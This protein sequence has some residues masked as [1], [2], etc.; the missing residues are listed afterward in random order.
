[1][2]SC[3][4]KF[5]ISPLLSFGVW[6]WKISCVDWQCRKLGWKGF[7]DLGRKDEHRGKR[8]FDR[9]GPIGAVVAGVVANP[10][11]RVLFD[12]ILHSTP[13]PRE[14]NSKFHT[15]VPQSKS[16]TNFHAR[17]NST[18]QARTLPT[19]YL[20]S[21]NSRKWQTVSRPLRALGA[22][23]DN[24]SSLP[25]PSSRNTGYQSYHPD[26]ADANLREQNQR[27]LEN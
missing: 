15:E 2:F 3:L 8:D 7:L 18:L 11:R 20:C 12:P 17:S 27:L 21:R 19:L 23:T 6:S 25:G 5:E 16:C 24:F 26:T 14:P 1:M 4:L 22:Y 9:R 10:K 13:S